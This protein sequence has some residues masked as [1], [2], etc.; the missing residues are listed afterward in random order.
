MALLL[1]KKVI[2]PAKYLD[3]A[4]IFLDKSVNIL[5]EQTRANELAIKLEKDKQPPYRLIYS[6]GPVELKTFKIYIKINL[7]NGVIRTSKLLRSAMIL[8]VH[9]PNSSFCLYVN[10]WKLNNL[11]IKNWHLLWLIGESIDWLD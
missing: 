8:F 6:L 4:D 3:F 7:P 11:I 1:A 2:I 5:P 10:Y 9:K